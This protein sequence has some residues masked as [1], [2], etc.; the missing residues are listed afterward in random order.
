MRFDLAYTWAAHR[1]AIF[2]DG[3][4]L[5]QVD[6]PPRLSVRRLLRTAPLKDSAATDLISQALYTH[7]WPV[8]PLGHDSLQ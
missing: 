7:A 1:I 4:F 3:K 8:M 6:T 2:V 5:K